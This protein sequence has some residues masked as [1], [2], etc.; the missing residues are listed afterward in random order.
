MSSC[1]APFLSR[2]S[3]TIALSLA[4]TFF[5]V[6]TAVESLAQDGNCL[7]PLDRE[8]TELWIDASTGVDAP[9]RGCREQPLATLDFLFAALEEAPVRHLSVHFA[10]GDY[11]IDNEI[12]NSSSGVPRSLAPRLETLR[13]LG[14]GSEGRSVRISGTDTGRTLFH[15]RAASS[16]EDA[17]PTGLQELHLRGIEFHDAGTAFIVDV[18]SREPPP[19][20]RDAAPLSDLRIDIEDCAFRSIDSAAVAVYAD[21]GLSTEASL[22]DCEFEACGNGV[23]FELAPGAAGE[24]IVEDSS[25]R[26]TSQLLPELLLEN[27]IEMHLGRRAQ[28]VLRFERNVVDGTVSGIRLSTDDDSTVAVGE[29]PAGA[30][31]LTRLEALVANSL[32]VSSGAEACENPQAGEGEGPA[33]LPCELA[34]ALVIE[35]WPDRDLVLDVHHNTFWGLREEIFRFTEQDPNSSVDFGDLRFANNVVA[36]S[37]EYAG[38]WTNVA[39]QDILRVTWLANLV[40]E[41]WSDLAGFDRFA[42]ESW[43][44]AP[45]LAVELPR[46]ELSAASPG[47]D[48][49]V[50]VRGLE[51]GDLDVYGECRVQL[52]RLAEGGTVARADLGAVETTGLC[53]DDPALN[54]F[55]RGDCNG[56][57]S[58]EIGD[59][60]RIFGFLFLGEAA[61]ACDDACDLTDNAI[62][63]IS[64]GIYLLSFL[65]LGG[66]APAAPFPSAS[67]DPTPDDGL[68][69]ADSTL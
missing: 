42:D 24:L 53:I 38:Q 13:L 49:A 57:G 35:A 33:R 10:P 50:D 55:V 60:I 44:V 45:E 51:P 62:H 36:G 63:D 15:L 1:S 65:F 39:G 67:I 43:F 17:D 27:A 58:V 32:F 21:Y 8:T 4:C 9:D 2:V 30:P 46:Y 19:Q 54:R 5:G 48:A 47:I 11:S 3:C 20:D 28:G 7:S 29:L 31:P 68:L 34:A 26:H 59:S 23:R 69:C 56:D 66:P 12:D 52:A 25:F 6:S 14:E 41:A 16:F 64:D 61:P 37:A 22:R 40:P 18:E